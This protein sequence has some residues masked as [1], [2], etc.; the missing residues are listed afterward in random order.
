VEAPI[1]RVW[2]HFTQPE[3]IVNWNFASSNWH[4]PEAINTLKPGAVFTWR[5]EA[6]DGSFGFDFSGT[7]TEIIPLDEI[8]YT[9]EDGRLVLINFDD[10]GRAVRV[11]EAFEAEDENSN[12]RQK[13]GWQAILNRFKYYS[14]NQEFMH[15]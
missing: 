2:E 4:C 14:E 5:M 15:T 8:S 13:A 11:T 10:L 12:D 9:L 3:H 7:Y 1:H 6:K